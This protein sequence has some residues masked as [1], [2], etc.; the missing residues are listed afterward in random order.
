[1]S[2]FG[3]GKRFVQGFLRV[4]LEVLGIFFAVNNKEF[5]PLERC[6]VRL[7]YRAQINPAETS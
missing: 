6:Q 4:P 3:E 2:L 1:M 7:C 5:S